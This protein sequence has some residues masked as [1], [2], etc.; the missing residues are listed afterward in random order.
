MPMLLARNVVT[1]AGTITA[2]SKGN[3]ATVTERAL[4][5]RMSPCFVANFRTEGSAMSDCGETIMGLVGQSR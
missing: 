4:W 1:S 2:A 5:G 3:C